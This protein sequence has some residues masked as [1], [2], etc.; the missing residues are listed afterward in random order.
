MLCAYAIRLQRELREENVFS[1]LMFYFSFVRGTSLRGPVHSSFLPDSAAGWMNLDPSLQREGAKNSRGHKKKQKRTM[2]KQNWG[3]T[4]VS[5]FMFLPSCPFWRVFP[6]RLSR[7]SGLT[8]LKNPTR[9]FF[10]DGP[11]SFFFIPFR[12]CCVFFDEAP[13]PVFFFCSP[14]MVCGPVLAGFAESRHAGYPC[15]RRCPPK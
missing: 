14:C 10:W 1:G 12:C 6:R 9:R 15:G 2:E 8:R 3:R 11:P 4:P 5:F 13:F 7:F